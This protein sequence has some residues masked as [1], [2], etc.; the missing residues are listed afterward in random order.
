MT[1]SGT[2]TRLHLDERIRDRSA[3][4]T[5][6]QILAVIREAQARLVRLATEVT[7]ETVGLDNETGRAIVDS[8]AS[9]FASVAGGEGDAGR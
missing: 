8:F 5:A 6:E 4:R 9:R 7:A 2:V 3:A 1:S